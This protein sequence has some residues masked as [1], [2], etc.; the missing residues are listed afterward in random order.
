MASE[1]RYHK[2]ND[3][4]S[5]L[6]WIK[7]G[8]FRGWY[9][10]CPLTDNLVDRDG[11]DGLKGDW[12]GN[13]V[14][15]NPPYSNPLRWVEKAIRESRKG[16]I[17]VLLLKHDSSTVWWAKLHEAG[18]H[19]LPIMGRLQFKPRYGRRKGRRAAAPFPSVLAVLYPKRVQS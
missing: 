7:D 2:G 4:Y 10:P 17:I 8:L 19:F 18:A 16:K 5:T 12:V 6:N 13:K 9:D 11:C 3:Q 14:F 15:V 1:N